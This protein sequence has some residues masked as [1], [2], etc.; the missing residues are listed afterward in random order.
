MS[1]E[2]HRKRA[3]RQLPLSYKHF[4][5][6]FSTLMPTQTVSCSPIYI[7][8]TLRLW[9]CT[10]LP[11][12]SATRRLSRT[13]H[14][15]FLGWWWRPW[16]RRSPSCPRTTADRAW[17]ATVCPPSYGPHRPRPHPRR[18]GRRTSL[19]SRRAPTWGRR[20]RAARRRWA[21]TSP[22]WP[23]P[24]APLVVLVRRLEVDLQAKRVAILQMIRHVVWKPLGSLVVV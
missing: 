17:S 3:Y 13:R 14:S 6:S 8:K 18:P 22:G 12:S 5:R 10:R 20:R 15:R 11:P 2:Q 7:V 9:C 16:T 21:A 23:T 4:W 1:N 19:R 24:R